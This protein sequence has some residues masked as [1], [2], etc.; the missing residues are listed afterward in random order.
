MS[1]SPTSI[2]LILFHLVILLFAISDLKL[3]IFHVHISR[4]DRVPVEIYI[5]SSTSLW[6][7]ILVG[8]I[9]NIFILISSIINLYIL[10]CQRNLFNKLGLSTLILVCLFSIRFII[11]IILTKY[12]NGLSTPTLVE[13]S[14]F[15]ASLSLEEELTT[16]MLN[17]LIK[18]IGLVCTIIYCFKQ[19]YKQ[20]SCVER[21]LETKLISNLE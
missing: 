11:N 17:W 8:I 5:D 7:P 3:F 14:F 15:A 18:M 10:L 19:N 16:I 6:Y 21:Q 4:V 13:R 1:S 9:F 20:T 2:L 12:R